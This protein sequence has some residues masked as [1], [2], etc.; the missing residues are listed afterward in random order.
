MNSYQGAQQSH[1]HCMVCGLHDENPDSLGLVFSP[2]VDG[3]V[4]A[5]FVVSQRHQ[6]YTGLLHGGM[7]ST[8]LDAAMT[9]CLFMQGIQALTAE[10]T[11]RFMAPIHIGQGITVCS[12]L[13]GQRRGIYQLEAWLVA[14]HQRVA[15]ASAKFIASPNL[16]R[17]LPGV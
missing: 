12:K 16:S 11:V 5:P 9:H 6:G 15:R 13:L 17:H 4:S 10:L 1:A 8:L 3:S 2:H 14:G 7:T